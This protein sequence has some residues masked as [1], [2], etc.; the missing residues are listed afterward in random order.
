MIGLR[1]WLMHVV[2]DRRIRMPR[3]KA[4]RGPERSPEYRAWIRNYPCV[5]CGR[6]YAIEAAHTGPHGISQK[7]SDRSCIP[8]CAWCHR[9]GRYSLHRLG[10][11]W[12]EAFHQVSIAALVAEFNQEWRRR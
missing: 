6:C 2:H 9:L 8:L 3:R 5:T 4:R 11:T 12:F 10:P 7:S 1:K